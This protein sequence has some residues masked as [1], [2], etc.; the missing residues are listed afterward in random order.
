MGPVIRVIGGILSCT[1]ISVS[2]LLTVRLDRDAG[3]TVIESPNN[4]T[5]V[6]WQE[7]LVTPRPSTAINRLEPI[8]FQLDPLRCL[9]FP[10]VYPVGSLSVRARHRQRHP[11][12]QHPVIPGTDV[13][14]GSPSR[15][16]PSY[17][18]RPPSGAPGN[19]Q[20]RSELP[21]GPSTGP[22]GTTW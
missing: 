4:F 10:A 19:G 18:L 3:G 9:G 1:L 7:Y 8:S 14:V 21:T 11:A 15:S 5:S 13:S 22:Q 2:L 6:Q 17:C 12:G 16:V 20:G